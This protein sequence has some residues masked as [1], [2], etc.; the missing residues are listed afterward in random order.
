[1][2]CT[3][4]RFLFRWAILLAFS[5]TISA[6]LSAAAAQTLSGPELVKHLQE[7]GYVLLMRH[8]HSPATPP[9]KTAADTG[10]VKLER[11]LDETGRRT[12][13]AM[14]KA[15]RTLH[16]S[17]GSVLSSPTY[18]ALETI[19]LAKL[20]QPKTFTELGDGGQSMMASAVSGQRNWLRSKVAESP[21]PGSN[22]V[23]VTHMPN[24]QT[25][26]GELASG[27]ADGETLIFRPDRHDGADLV[28]RV[29]IEDWPLLAKEGLK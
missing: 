21:K 2:Y 10:N 8:A 5:V 24:I 22:T 15:L 26:Y 3:S 18:R 27:L 4:S 12:A 1:M 29:K 6:S 17:F 25:A 9:E 23:I 13:S 19:R 20:G 28:G 7:G 16:I 11:Q 14:G